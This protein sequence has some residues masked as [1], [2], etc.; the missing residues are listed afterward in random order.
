MAGGLSS[1]TVEIFSTEDGS[2]ASQQRLAALGLGAA[3]F[4]SLLLV[5]YVSGDWQIAGI[6]FATIIALAAAL[7]FAQSRL[8]TDQQVAELLS[9]I[10]YRA[11]Y[12]ENPPA[13]LLTLSAPLLSMA[14]SLGR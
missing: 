2:V 5:W 6:A 9:V 13:D 7:I 4:V 14:A 11:V 1:S 10:W 12:L 3:L 8:R